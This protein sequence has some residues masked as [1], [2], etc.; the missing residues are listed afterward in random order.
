MKLSAVLLQAS[1]APVFRLRGSKT[2]LPL[3]ASAQNI[4]T[5]ISLLPESP[6]TPAEFPSNVPV[7]PFSP[8]FNLPLQRTVAAFPS[9]VLHRALILSSFSRTAPSRATALHR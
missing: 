1:A 4:A 6:P 7:S 5:R 2:A 8:H 3:T 9:T